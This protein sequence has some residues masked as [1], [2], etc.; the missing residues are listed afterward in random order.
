LHGEKDADHQDYENHPGADQL[1][2]FHKRDSPEGAGS[3]KGTAAEERLNGNSD[4]PGLDAYA[5]Y[6]VGGMR[7]RP[8]V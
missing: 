5:K 1:G 7:V 3:G 6:A 2:R 8:G 4:R